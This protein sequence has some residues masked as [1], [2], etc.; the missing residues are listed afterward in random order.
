[1]SLNA[2]YGSI[3]IHFIKRG[4]LN[5]IL[6]CL[7]FCGNASAQSPYSLNTKN[8]IYWLSSG[9]SILGLG[10]GLGTATKPLTADE[11]LNLN[12]NDVNSFDRFATTNYD[13]GI[14][15][16]SD[17]FLYSSFAGAI[18][19]LF[20]KKVRKDVITLGI[21]YTEA[22]TITAGTTL[23]TKYITERNRPFVYNTNADLDEKLRRQARHSFFSGHTS[24]AA[25]N[26]FFIAKV[27]SDYHP[28]SKY[29][30][31]VWAGAVLIPA[32]TGYA[33]VEG[34]KHFPT[35]VIAGYAVG[36]LAGYFV[37]HFHKKKNQKELGFHI[38]PSPFGVLVNV[39]LN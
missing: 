8:E 34:G 33:R 1:M 18:P 32:A 12:P 13:L 10:Y 20:D 16:L 30:P 26:T 35:D 29:K 7:F 4:L 31:L 6:G 25:M 5:L 9:I 15:R 14:Q 39:D 23:L 38:Y 22:A 36:A 2:L 3:Q 19:F 27:F 17:G 24:I 28:D 11:I 21:I 37:P